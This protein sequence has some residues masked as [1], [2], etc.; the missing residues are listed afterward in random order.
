VT[1]RNRETHP[2]RQLAS[3]HGFACAVIGVSSRFRSRSR[4]ERRQGHHSPRQRKFFSVF[5]WYRATKVTNLR[6]PASSSFRRRGLDVSK[7]TWLYRDQKV[8]VG[9]SGIASLRTQRVDAARSSLKLSAPNHLERHVQT[10]GRDASVPRGTFLWNTW[11]ILWNNQDQ[12]RN[13]LS[14]FEP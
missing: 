12:P 2:A 7:P 6:V 9:I 10:P 13:G 8:P 5:R 14:R 1:L 4:K 3:Y 11:N